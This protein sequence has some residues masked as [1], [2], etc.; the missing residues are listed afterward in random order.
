MKKIF[1]FLFVSLITGKVSGQTFYTDP[2]RAL[3]IL[4]FTEQS[5]KTLNAQQRAQLVISGMHIFMEEEVS[6]TTDFQREFNE[7]LDQFNEVIQIA[8]EVYGIYYEITEVAKNIKELNSVV[9]DAPANALAVAFSSK[10]NKVYTDLVMT[11]L[12]IAKDIHKV[13]FSG[14]KMTEKERIKIILGMRPK[15]KKTN[16]QLRRMSLMIKYTTFL[17]VWN[18]IL[19]KHYFKPA[20]RKEIIL[21]C[22]QRWKGAWRGR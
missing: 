14:A 7:Y 6:A 3:T 4:N 16:H 20:N 19:D 2:G 18:D 13:C 11:S 5:K 22:Q 8:A 21:R 1:I 17:D 12:D 9:S 15:L 10:R